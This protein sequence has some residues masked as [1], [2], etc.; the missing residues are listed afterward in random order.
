MSGDDWR[1]WWLATAALAIADGDPSELDR[2]RNQAC[3]L[4]A[5]NRALVAPPRLCPAHGIHQSSQ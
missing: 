2:A 1:A 5:Q 3:A 4:I